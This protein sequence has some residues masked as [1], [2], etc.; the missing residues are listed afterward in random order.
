MAWERM[1]RTVEFIAEHQARLEANVARHDEEIATL[2]HLVGRLAL[3][4]I[5][6]TNRMNAL[7]A[8]FDELARRFDELVAVH[9]GTEERLNSF[10][11]FVEKYI[12][13]RK[14]D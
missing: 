3:A 12:S 7:T 10:I 9:K 4:E 8:R 2:T 5:E 6:L 13:S 14:G 1:E 11:T